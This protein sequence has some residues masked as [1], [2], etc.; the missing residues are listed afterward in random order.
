[1]LFDFIRAINKHI[2]ENGLD[3]GA[4]PADQAS[5]PMQSLR[6]MALTL[7]ELTAVLGLF[8]KPP[9]ASAGGDQ[10]AAELNQQ[11]MQLLIGLRKE[12]RERKDFALSDAIRNRLTEIGVAL[13]D[14]KE[15]T[16]WEL[17]R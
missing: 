9:L 6:L 11:L 14:K 3:Q 13:M 5:V 7:R 16:T 15:G 4:S 1:M 8:V 12:A 2:D 10:K 17:Q